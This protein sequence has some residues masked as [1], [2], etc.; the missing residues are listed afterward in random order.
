MRLRDWRW[1]RE[2]GTWELV[3]TG[4]ELS[5]ADSVALLL[6]GVLAVAGIVGAAIVQL[7]RSRSRRQKHAAA[8]Q[9]PPAT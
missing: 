1:N 2:A 9:P 5:P 3:E 7:V 4:E 6:P 8:P